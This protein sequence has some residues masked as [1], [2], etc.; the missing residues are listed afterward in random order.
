MVSG[1]KIL[2]EY[3]LWKVKLLFRSF[4]G[5]TSSPLWLNP[6]WTCSKCG[7]SSEADG[8]MMEEGRN[9]PFWRCCEL[10]QPPW[11]WQALSYPFSHRSIFWGGGILKPVLPSL[12]IT[13]ALIGAGRYISVCLFAYN[14]F[15]SFST[16]SI[17]FMLR[18]PQP[19]RCFYSWDKTQL[20]C[21]KHPH[22]LWLD[23]LRA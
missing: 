21:V 1:Q 9:I 6:V 18:P 11:A 8:G 10:F 13:R 15:C 19:S 5:N 20:A 4:S 23:K 3:N 12:G 2:S 22:F 7:I 16:L 14:S 17:F